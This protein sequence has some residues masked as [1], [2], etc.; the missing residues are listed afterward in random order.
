MKDAGKL[1]RRLSEVLGTIPRGR[2]DYLSVVDSLTLQPM[3]KIRRP[4]LLAAAVRIGKTRL[5][6]N[7]IIT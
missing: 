3:K 4:A 5:I 1:V 6:D 2:V 7:V